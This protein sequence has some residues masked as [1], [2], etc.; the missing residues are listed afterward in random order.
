M[1]E[2]KLELRLSDR[3]K[4][5]KV[6][7]GRDIDQPYL[8]TQSH[9]GSLGPPAWPALAR[10]QGWGLPLA[11]FPQQLWQGPTSLLKG[12][13]Q[14]LLGGKGPEGPK[15]TEC[16]LTSRLPLPHHTDLGQ[17][18]P[19]CLP[20]LSALPYVAGPLGKASFVSSIPSPTAPGSASVP[21]PPP[22][23]P[24]SSGFLT[25]NPPFLSALRSPLKMTV[26]LPLLL[27]AVPSFLG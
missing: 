15:P 23:S 19:P 22:P 1:A 9:G 18:C 14:A 16:A 20:G 6:T 7:P 25:S 3:S 8:E 12:H 24:F 5:S 26:F 2:P 11:R 21:P 10:M 4:K 17:H 13:T 27:W